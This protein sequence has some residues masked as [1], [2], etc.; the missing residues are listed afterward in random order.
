MPKHTKSWRRQDML[1]GSLVG[2]NRVKVLVEL[3]I[4]KKLGIHP[5]EEE[6]VVPRQTPRP[7]YASRFTASAPWW[8][9]IYKR[10]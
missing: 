6:R 4:L 8:N 7:Q 5:I 9:D 1:L 2:K 3:E 10:G